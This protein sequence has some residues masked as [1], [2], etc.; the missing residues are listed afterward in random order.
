MI[1]LPDY[2]KFDLGNITRTPAP[3]LRYHK[4]I[5]F[6]LNLIKYFTSFALSKLKASGYT[7]P[8]IERF[9]VANFDIPTEGTWLQLLKNILKIQKDKDKE[10]HNLFYSNHR[11]E[12]IKNFIN[13]YSMFIN[14][15]FSNRNTFT[16]IEYLEF[17]IKL[18]NNSVSHSL[19]SENQANSFNDV[20]LPLL[21]DILMHFKCIF[22]IPIF[23]IDENAEGEFEFVQV[24]GNAVSL[25]ESKISDNYKEEGIYF[26]L[27][28]KIVLAKPLFILRDGNVLLYNRFDK[29]HKKIQYYGPAGKEIYIKTSSQNIHELFNIDS[30][31]LNLKPIQTFVK[32]AKN[33][34]LHNVPEPDFKD[35][36]GRKDELSDLKKCIAHKRHFLTALDGIGGV[37]KTAIS[38]KLCHDILDI[39]TSSELYFEYI[40]WV[41]SKNTILKNGRI[42]QLTQSFEHL[43]QLLDI[44]LDVLGFSEL[45][46]YEQDKKIED[47]YKIASETK[48][49]IVIDNLE[50]LKK[51]NLKI[52]WDFL[53]DLPSPTK[54]LLTSR[55]YH[56]DVN[57]HVTIANLSNSDSFE[58]I[59][60]FCDG[61]GLNR[62]KIEAYMRD[63]V[64]ISSGLPIAIT[65][66]L[67]QVFLGKNFHVIKKSIAKNEDD[68][69]KFCFEGQYNLLT[70][71]HRTVLLLVCIST[72]DLSYDSLAYIL[73][74][75]FKLSLYDL[76]NQLKDLSLINVIYNQDIETYAVL[77]LIKN[78]ILNINNNPEVL[79]YLENKLKEF[80]QLKDIESFKLFVIEERS[81][82]KGSLIPR[83]LSDKAMK[84]A[85]IGEI[86]EA[87]AL[88]RKVTRDYSHES[89]VWYIYS[90][91]E[92]QYKNNLQEAIACL[93][94]A[95]NVKPNYLYLKH[96][97][98]HFLKLKNY[99][100]ALENYQKAREIASLDRNQ[101]EMLFSI[102]VAEFEK[103]KFIRKKMRNFGSG[104]KTERNICYSNIISNLENYLA[105]TPQ[106]YDG[107]LIR[108]FR[109]LSES[110]LG[111]GNLDSFNTYIDKAIVLSDE[112]PILIEFKS[113]INK[114]KIL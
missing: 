97:G 101:D 66:I 108:I 51:E 77:P 4:I 84:H 13:A 90:I 41:S 5:H 12:K 59:Y 7:S 78:Y 6:H 62:K 106:I 54:V 36:I 55:E 109:M 28:N 45:K 63:I 79:K 87:D 2:F 17:I 94:R 19:I 76:I 107:K 8:E 52:I 113:T 15:E 57:Q 58:F 111:L 102:S 112:D 75:D 96:I 43:N 46:E 74:L 71:E 83:K 95:N 85:E 67:G 21:E 20:I 25:S 18:K 24:S 37:G 70:E 23:Y 82:D 98:D 35:F 31:L 44:T 16:S 68:L 61:I 42:V 92:S 40:I 65:S 93:R 100:S 33:G 32:K 48:I 11:S 105:V 81:I 69:T 104:N 89:Y 56:F 27:D 34:I 49:L 110:Y 10:L 9:I 14:K 50:T 39:E 86:D 91:Y 38:L 3:F 53:Y 26:L 64:E 80:Y 99:D 60:N 47:I 114:K 30:L 1:H 22:E 29:G 103:V 88:F 73:E 72:D